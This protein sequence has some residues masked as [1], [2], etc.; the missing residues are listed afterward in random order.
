MSTEIILKVAAVIAALGTIGGTFV[1]FARVAKK[2][3][4]SIS[5]VQEGVKCM[6]RA[7]M[8]STYYKNNAGNTITQYEFQ[9]FELQYTAY[10]RL[11]GNSFIDKI[12]E[13]IKDWEVTR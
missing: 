6:L 4:K 3:S 7:A 2:L 10:K 1:Y 13:D 9:N 5:D 11:G 8:L 12:H